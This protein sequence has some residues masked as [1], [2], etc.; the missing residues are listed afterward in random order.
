[1]ASLCLVLVLCLRLTFPTLAI[2]VTS[3][4]I[5]IDL[6]GHTMTSDPGFPAFEAESGYTVTIVDTSAPRLA[7]WS[8]A[9]ASPWM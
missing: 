9:S 5:T 4:D 2:T 1:M 6:N 3:H 7:S 8:P